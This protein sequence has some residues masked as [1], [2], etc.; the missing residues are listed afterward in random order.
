MRYQGPDDSILLPTYVL[1]QV[2]DRHVSVNLRDKA[3]GFDSWNS[4]WNETTI[5][6]LPI[7][8]VITKRD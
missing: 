4:Y 3:L 6:L 8:H 7:H 5:K 1:L 2:V